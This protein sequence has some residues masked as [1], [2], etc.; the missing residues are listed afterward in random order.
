MRLVSSAFENCDSIPIQ[1][2]GEGEDLSPPLR[3]QDVP[4]GTRS[5]ALICDDPDA[6]NGTWDHW[7]IYNIPPDVGVLAEGIKDLPYGIQSGHNSWAKTGYGGPLPPSGKKH[8]YFFT[9]YALDT[10]LQLPKDVKKANLL[11]AMQRHIL[12]EASLV[13]VY[14]SKNKK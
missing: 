5:L 12:A 9:L 10:V 3:W 11:K 14:E 6:P 1:Y 7:I 13:G 8:R 2:T 4:H